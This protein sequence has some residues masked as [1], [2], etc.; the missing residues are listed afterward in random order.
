MDIEPRPATIRVLKKDGEKI[1]ETDDAE[2]NLVK[3]KIKSANKSDAKAIK[4]T[5]IEHIDNCQLQYL[6]C[7]KDV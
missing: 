1:G 7:H 5:S 3:M 2:L 4:L 6:L